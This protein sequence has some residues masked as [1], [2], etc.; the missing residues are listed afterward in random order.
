[1][2]VDTDITAHTNANPP[3]VLGV[4]MNPFADPAAVVHNPSHS[5]PSLDNNSSVARA[6][7][8]GCPTPP[9]NH[10]RNACNIISDHH[11]PENVESIVFSDP[12]RN[13]NPLVEGATLG[14]TT[15]FT[16]SH[17]P[18]YAPALTDHDFKKAG[19]IGSVSSG[20]YLD[21]ATTSGFSLTPGASKK[22]P[23]S[24]PSLGGL[25]NTRTQITP[26]A[27]FDM[28]VHKMPSTLDNVFE[29]RVAQGGFELYGYKPSEENPNVLAPASS[30]GNFFGATAFRGTL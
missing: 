13:T 10:G 11:P 6:K 12:W 2:Q 27:P 23:F 21:P 28:K 29:T 19:N 17:N 16:G 22:P 3:K 7:A 24:I 8:R 20:V 18:L 30:N 9:T 5:T 4:G 26:P 15:S 25:E 14:C 1:M